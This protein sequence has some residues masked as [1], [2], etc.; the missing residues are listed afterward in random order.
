MPTR[1]SITD[2]SVNQLTDIL[3]DL[4]VP[5]YR[6]KQ[7]LNWLYINNAV[8]FSQITNLPK[9]LISQLESMYT[10][11]SLS[12]EKFF[13]SKDGKTKKFLF[14]TGDGEIIEGVSMLDGK[15]HTL[16]LSTQSGC[17][18]GCVFCAS[19]KNGFSR[20][21]STGEII[22]QI[23]LMTQD[24][25]AT[26][27]VFMGG[28]EPLANFDNFSKAYKTIIDQNC[29]GIG[30]RKITVSTAGY[31]PGIKQLVKSDLRPILALS[32]HSPFDENR[33]KNYAYKQKVSYRSFT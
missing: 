11:C 15:R 7:L 29:M 16:C 18:Y 23:R 26:N 3:A 1:K 20:N 32:L 28:G 8:D 14:K 17:K 2:L 33:S 5:E 22:D 25:P 13:L 31:L 19:G 30:Q 24:K 6:L 4:N 21:L 12:V 10:A 9:N 27:I